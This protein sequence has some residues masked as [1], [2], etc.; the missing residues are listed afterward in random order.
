MRACVLSPRPRH[1]HTPSSGLKPVSEP[2]SASQPQHR[3]ARCSARRAADANRARPRSC[4]SRRGGDALVEA[5]VDRLLQPGAHTPK[6]CVADADAAKLAA[7]IVFEHSCRRSQRLSR[8]R[9]VKIAAHADVRSDR[10]QR[11]NPA[12]ASGPAGT[13][14]DASGAIDIGGS[15]R[16]GSVAQALRGNRVG[17]F[18]HTALWRWRGGR[19]RRQRELLAEL[20]GM[21]ARARVLQRDSGSR[22]HAGGLDV[23][24]GRYRAGDADKCERALHTRQPLWVIP[25][26]LS[27]LVGVEAAQKS[28]EAMHTGRSPL[29]SA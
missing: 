1:V 4:C 10:L 8:L 20:Y 11:D 2:N 22:G 26:H 16:R 13:A 21:A 29:R 9:R 18:G 15:D 14:A 28:E 23:E 25:Q 27:G 17:A 5:S 24:G 3:L 7:V 19:R 6:A 12:G